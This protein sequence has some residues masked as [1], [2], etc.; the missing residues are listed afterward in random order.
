MKWNKVY[1]KLSLTM[2]SL[3][4]VIL[5][6][7]SMVINQLFSNF[8][9]KKAHEE[10][11]ELALHLSVML[12]DRI[13]AVETMAEFSEASIYLVNGQGQF[14]DMS[15]STKQK[16]IQAWPNVW[17]NAQ[18]L[19]GKQIEKEFTAG[20]QLY[21]LHGI[22]VHSSKNPVIKGIYVVSSLEHMIES[23]RSV[24]YLI[25]LAGFG[26]LLLA[27]GCIFILAKKLSAPLVEMEA[28]TR[29]IAKGELEVRLPVRSHDEVGSLSSAINDLAMELKRYRDTRS[30]FFANV[31]HELRTPVTYLKGYANVLTHGLV[32][33]EEEKQQYL[34]IIAD[35]AH[36]L[37]V[38]INDLFELA[39]M[40]EGKMAF[41][42]ESV[43]VRRAVE[44]SVNK[45]RI[46]AE[47]KGLQLVSALE[48]IPR[49]FVDPVRLEQ[50]L[51]NLLDNAIRY[52][53]K[54]T[55]K[56][57]LQQENGFGVILISDSGSGIPANELPYIFERFYRVE[58]SR[59]REFG[60]TG[61]GLAIAQKLVQLQGGTIEVESAMG[62]G[63]V[64]RLSFPFV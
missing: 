5:V 4:L 35:E 23:I 31:S 53:T 13:Y 43:D 9:T 16:K 54:G 36:R 64:F 21:L 32:D 59:S 55:I 29:N 10:A 27:L 33:H 63:T 41:H 34:H 50:V 3:F 40:E 48:T 17:E 25:G 22:P 37:T 39:K 6:L 38:I 62:Q 14:L 1:L 52:T 7:L 56:L 49:C 19:Q 46:K 15:A 30:E 60:G 18:L 28:A 57:T 42:L 8:Y 26:T 12:R 11:N 2:F 44:K 51:L 47:Q 61:L 24:R 20:D 45:V 58:K